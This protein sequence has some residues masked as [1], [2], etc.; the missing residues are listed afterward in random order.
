MKVLFSL[1]MLVLPLVARAE[2]VDIGNDELRKLVAQGVK[3]VD[4][5]TVGEW[6]QTGVVA[7]SHMIT[8]FD[9]RGQVNPDWKR[10]VA[11][12]AP[13]DQPI[14]LICRSGN[15]SGIAAK[16][17][18]EASPTRRIYNVREGMNGWARAGQPI[19]SLQQNQ[20]TAGIR[21]APVC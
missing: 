19:V 3:L 5:R 12:L 4:L 2:I 6:R 14:V 18:A 10:D 16:M 20:K 8:L 1:L 17:L 9:E 13:A 21:C 15:R 11:A 7:G